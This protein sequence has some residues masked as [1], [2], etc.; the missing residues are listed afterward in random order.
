MADKIKF[1]A[2]K[3]ADLQNK[4]KV[5]GQVY[6]AIDGET[7][8]IAFDVDGQTRVFM[9]KASSA[10]SATQDSAGNVISKYIKTIQLLSGDDTRFQYI[11]GDGSYVPSKTTGIRLNFV[12]RAGDTMTG[13]LTAKG[14]IL[15]NTATNT[16][17]FIISRTGSAT[18]ECTTFGQNDQGLVIKSI[19]DEASTFIRF[20]ME[21][22]DMEA[23]AG[24][25][26]NSGTI[27]FGLS[28]GKTTV[29]ADYFSGQA[30]SAVKDTTGNTIASTFIKNLILNNHETQPYYQLV[31]GTG[32]DKSTVNLPVASATNAGVV[33]VGA[34]SFKGQK[35]FI[36]SDTTTAKKSS[37]IVLNANGKS[38][39]GIEF[40]RGDAAD[41]ASWQI[42]N[43]GGNFIF[44]TDYSDAVQTTYNVESL[45][46]HYTTGAAQVPYLWVN[47]TSTQSGYRLYVNGN[48]YLNGK[49]TIT[50]ATTL[51]STL[52]FSGDY[53]TPNR[54]MWT[55]AGNVAQAAYHF[56]NS[57]QVAINSTSVPS[58]NFYVNGTSGFSGNIDI[59]AGDEDRYLTFG[60][61]SSTGYDWRIGYLGAGSGD[62]NYLV[63]QSSKTDGKYVNALRFGLTTLDAAF[64][65][66]V[67]PLNG[68]AGNQCL[69]TSANRWPYI[70]G[71]IGDFQ[72][73]VTASSFI[74]DN[75]T[76][77][78]GNAMNIVSANTIVFKKSATVRAQFDT[79]GHFLP[80]ADNTYNSGSS[81]IK[82]KNVYAVTFQGNATSAN[83]V[84]NALSVNG[85]TFDGSA[86]VTVGTITTAYGGTGVTE[87]TTNR[88]VWSKS[89]TQLE[90]NNHYA[91]ATKIA[92]NSG[93]EPSYNLY[94]KGTTYI[95]GALYGR[96]GANCVT[97][98]VNGDAATYYPVVI[99]KPADYYPGL[100]LSVTRG[101]NETAPASWNSSTHMGGLT[102]SIL[103]N[104]T[105]YWDGNGSGSFNW[106]VFNI[107]Q[108]HE[109]YTTMVADID[110]STQGLVIWLRGG[111]AV[112]HI[113]SANGVALTTS[114]KLTSFTDSADRAF[115]PLTKINTTSLNQK[116]HW[117]LRGGDSMLGT[118][119]A[120]DIIPSAHDTYALGGSSMRWSYIYGAIGNFSSTVTATTFMASTENALSTSSAMRIKS[121]STMYLN[122]GSSTSLIFQMN[123]AAHARF[124]TAGHFIPETDNT[125]NIGVDS[126]QRWKNVYAVTFHGALSGNASSAS[127]VNNALTING[128]TYNGSAAIDV[129]TLGT[130]YGGTG[131]NTHTANRLVYST[132]A[133]SIQAANHHYVDATHLAVNSNSQPSYN[134]YVNGTSYFS[135]T[136]DLSQN[137]VNIMFRRGTGYDTTISYQTSGNEALV[138]AT[139]NAVTSFIFINGEDTA[140]NI[141]SDRWT[142]ITPAL[143]IKNNSVYIGSLIAN[144]TTPAYKFYVN[145]TSY[146]NGAVTTAGLLT[147][148]TG[149]SHSGIKMGTTYVTSISGDV[150][151]QNNGAIRFGTDDWDYNCWA[152]LKYVHSSKTISLGLADGST[153]TA[154]AAQ[155]G[156]TLALPG[157]R[158]LSINGKIVIDANDSW[159]R[160]NETK[161]FSS[162]IYC[163][164]NVLRTDYRLEV[165]SSGAYFYANNSG[166]G[167]FSSTLG[168]AGTNTSYKLYVNGA[169]YLN[170]KL[171]ISTNAYTPFSTQPVLYF[172][173]K[174]LSWASSYIYNV[175][176]LLPVLTASNQ[177]VN[178][179][180]DGKFLLWKNGANIYDVI[181][182]GMNCAYNQMK[183]YIKANGEYCSGWKL[184]VCKYGGVSY[185]ALKVPYHANP[186]NQVEFCGH[187][188][189]DLTGGT[190][191][192]A[193]PYVVA[194]YNENTQTVL[195]SE[196][197]S[198]ITETLTTTY[199][200]SVVSTSSWFTGNLTTTGTI[201]GSKVYNAVWND[202]AEYFE[203]GENTEA[204]DIVSLDLNS[205][206]E[207]YIKA[208]NGSVVCGIHSDSYGHLI[209]GKNLPDNYKGSFEDYNNKY[210]IPVGMIGR[211][212][213]KV[214]G[215]IQK[216]DA[217]Y[218]SQIPGVGC[219]KTAD[220]KPQSFVGYACE[221]YNSKDIGKIKILLRK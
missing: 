165:G 151:F 142:K 173:N 169:S 46:L 208:V 174:S 121:G 50:D 159:L 143:Q 126:T 51:A 80:G 105:R 9:D 49:L 90:A 124:D 138:A 107:L 78:S 68:S 65:G 81:S 113:F 200:T 130:A 53:Y 218:A 47:P 72:S 56:V 152:G 63:F 108:H 171:T 132:A 161:A 168:I 43:H 188:R 6:F 8:K 213:C 156:G 193:L 100:I 71:V 125:Y 129:G 131:V 35:T 3:L 134:F 163:G 166:N 210:F 39:T 89:A 17:N 211:V 36:Y 199:V 203:R 7:G 116:R 115:A 187:V 18:S 84:N 114:I 214:F 16:N 83:K 66:N 62:A 93:S 145:G 154:N 104:G 33:T 220:S 123:G 184:C 192:V 186:Y 57:T 128:K 24:A 30:S 75:Y 92:I 101:Y 109:T 175:I 190:G 212:Y 54:M 140:T 205:D 206:E 191:S 149:S 164:S 22:T 48:S 204:G 111:G 176:L 106:N 195:N 207:K 52:G 42:V 147:V 181:E 38:P 102:L 158:Y 64:G 77:T 217:I 179:M 153:F 162:G 28:G 27:T 87:H 160:I 44:R 10:D 61:S 74:S 37:A 4:P 11:L 94:V 167:Y 31:K 20:E 157:I 5:Q 32:D 178:N 201:T 58:T 45:K 215:N 34:Q 12:S 41:A 99:D 144:G 117:L 91:S 26:K 170:G 146:F 177:S 194:Y 148:S 150:I 133:N 216:G 23:N 95:D 85:K 55:N 88:L 119:T 29:T 2:G 79:N 120:R 139:K 82:W 155:S 25:G 141:A 59:W 122:R 1:L 118:L 76:S 219:V 112:Y 180:F 185:Y 14:G 60:Y 209:G 69:G 98:T 202:Y 19:N 13:L 198:S 21:A 136:I 135:N 96:L 197:N 182:V 67:Y 73:T 40:Y 137:L 127:K 103:W 86:A 172:V 183:Y 110:T 70:Y 221:N 97:I 196:V 189:S 15:V